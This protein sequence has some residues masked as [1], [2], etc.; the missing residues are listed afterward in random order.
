MKRIDISK[1][2]KRDRSSKLNQNKLD[3]LKTVI[4]LLGW[5]IGQTRPD[6]AFE[7][8]ML[9]SNSKNATGNEITQA[10]EILEKAKKENVILRFGLKGKIKNFKIIGFI[11]VSF[12]NL[13]DGS[14]QGYIIYLVNE[15]VECSQ[16]PLQSKK[17]KRVV[18]SVMVSGTL[19]Q[20]DCMQACHWIARLLNEI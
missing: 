14:S 10:K 20:V 9:S 7:T 18:K 1:E 12:G 17:W 11:G 8:C 19:I 6:L 13:S 5:I 3:S 2:R 4:G 15:I 16:L